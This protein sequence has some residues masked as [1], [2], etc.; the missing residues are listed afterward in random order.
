MK[1]TNNAILQDDGVTPFTVA[2]AD[3]TAR[4]AVTALE[5]RV[6]A[7]E[8]SN[9]NLVA[10]LA[11]T[12]SASGVRVTDASSSS[13]THTLLSGGRVME[14]GADENNNFTARILVPE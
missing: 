4:D 5:A 7:L 13:V 11:T 3:Q 6:A 2:S 14:I 9:A 12:V 1:I 10:L 8:A